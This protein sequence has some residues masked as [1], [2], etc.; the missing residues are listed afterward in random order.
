[1]SRASQKGRANQLHGLTA[2][3]KTAALS[4]LQAGSY[5]PSALQQ[6]TCPSGS[7]C[8]QQSSAPQP[9]SWATYCPAGTTT[10]RLS[11]GAFVGLLILLAAGWLAWETLH[12]LLRRRQRALLQ[13]ARAAASEERRADMLAALQSS[14]CAPMLTP[15]ACLACTTWHVQTLHHR[16]LCGAAG[17]LWGLDI[18]S[19]RWVVALML[20]VVGQVSQQGLTCAFVHVL[21][22]VSER[23]ARSRV[24]GCTSLL[25]CKSLPCIGP[26]VALPTAMQEP[27]MHLTQESAANASHRKLHWTVCPQYVGAAL[28]HWQSAGMLCRAPV[29]LQGLTRCQ[30]PI[31]VTVRH[32]EQRS[33]QILD[34]SQLHLV[35]GC[36]ERELN[37][38]LRL[39]AGRRSWGHR[40]P[41]W[42]GLCTAA[43]APRLS[44]SHCQ[45][46]AGYYTGQ[47][48]V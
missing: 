35:A 8:P 12:R 22:H 33:E 36:C 13:Q 20:E 44:T 5:C 47:S 43:N 31:S 41:Q 38:L 29:Q 4:L 15:V 7:F 27:A 34:H 23:P 21:T 17:E 46:H 39:I 25:L 2:A 26:D 9:C 16:N 6:L 3:C 19:S 32:S 24:T 42:A 18:G 48:Q 14:R 11:W 30:A 10:P 28:H 45:H 40:Q 37:I 1:M